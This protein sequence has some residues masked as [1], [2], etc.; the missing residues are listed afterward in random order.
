M[1]SYNFTIVDYFRPKKAVI[2]SEEDMS[3]GSRCCFGV[4]ALLVQILLHGEL[5]LT[6]YWIVQYRWNGL[7]FP[8]SFMGSE[9]GEGALDKEWNLHPV[10]M[11]A[12]FIY[13]MGQGKSLII[14]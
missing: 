5:A 14:S 13:C 7:G 11:I 1:Y 4:M 2:D 3:G 6:L 8:F 10:M 9:Q 12:G